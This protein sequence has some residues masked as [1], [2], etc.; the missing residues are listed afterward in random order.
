MN[1]RIESILKDIIS[2]TKGI[3]EILKKM[4]EK[5]PGITINMNTIEFGMDEGHDE[6]EPV[7]VD[8]LL[9][10]PPSS[11]EQEGS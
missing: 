7:D 2:E 4:R 5:F 1:S 3:E 11:T 9:G 8:K 6:G 10:M